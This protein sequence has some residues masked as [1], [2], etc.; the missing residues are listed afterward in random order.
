MG[1]YLTTGLGVALTGLIITL[2]ESVNAVRS[3]AV[4]DHPIS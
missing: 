2:V 4:E 3:K 1:P